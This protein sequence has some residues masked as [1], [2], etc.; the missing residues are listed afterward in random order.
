[1]P[2]IKGSLRLYRPGT[3]TVGFDMLGPAADLVQLESDLLRLEERI[4]KEGGRVVC[5]FARIRDVVAIYGGTN[6]VRFARSY[7]ERTPTFARC[8]LHVERSFV[9]R[10]VA[11]PIALLSPRV[12][13]KTSGDLDAVQQFARD[14]DPTFALHPFRADANAPSTIPPPRG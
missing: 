1:M 3:A 4:A 2:P 6:F 10:T 11:D 12:G 5:L 14:I 7:I 8:A 9:V 13:F